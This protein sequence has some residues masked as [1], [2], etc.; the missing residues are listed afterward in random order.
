MRL[1]F[2][3]QPPVAPAGASLLLTAIDI[4]HGGFGRNEGSVTLVCG[5]GTEEPLRIDSW[6]PFGVEVTLP[7][8]APRPGPYR[9]HVRTAAPLDEEGSSEF[10]LTM[11][12][13]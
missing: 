5:D 8:I 6:L 9:I 11:L 12:D 4:I 1:N 10:E 2:K 3:V 13:A 7:S